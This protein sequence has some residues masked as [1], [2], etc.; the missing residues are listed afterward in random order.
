MPLLQDSFCSEVYFWFLFGTLFLFVCYVPVREMVRRSYGSRILV[1]FNV[2]CG[3]KQ[4]S[5]LVLSRK[6]N[7]TMEICTVIY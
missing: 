5:I 6:L 4:N 3:K 1:F 7:G 2:S